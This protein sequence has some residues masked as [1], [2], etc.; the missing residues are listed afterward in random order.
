MAVVSMKRLELCG[1][2]RDRKEILEL[3]QKRAVV[4]VEPSEEGE[5][6]FAK[7]D[8]SGQCQEFLDNA[9]LLE[10]AVELLDHYAPPKKGM[11]SALA[12]RTPVTQR[13]FD[14]L[15]KQAPAL[16]GTAKELLAL[17]KER[18]DGTAQILRLEAQVESLK[19]WL[20][21]D[22]PMNLRETEST[23][24]FLGAFPQELD[25]AALKNS[26]AR[27]LPQVAG[28]EAEVLSSQP[29]QTCVFVV[30]C[31][32]DAPRVEE[33]LR[34]LGFTYP[35]LVTE[36]APQ[37]QAKQL[38]QEIQQA[39]QRN[40]QLEKEIAAR[41]EV[42]QDLLLAADYY[43]A[44]AE[45]YRVLGELWQ[46]PH[47]FWL[48]GYL[49]ASDA[50]GLLSELEGRFSLWA[51]AVEP[52]PDEDPPVK[53]KNGFFTE[54]VE[55]VVE[56]YSLPGKFEVDPC[57]V[58]AFFYY[59][60]FGMML[61]DAAY[62]ILTVIGSGAALKLFPNMEQKMQR[63]LR[64]FLFCGISTTVWGVL[65]G[66]Y[67]GDAI[68]VI[69]RTFFHTEVTI[70]A[71]W[72]EPLSDPM[73]LLIFSFGVGVAHL[74][75]GLGVQF[76]QLAKQRKYADAIYDVIFWYLLVGG[77][78]VVL[79][80]TEIFQNIAEL[81]FT[82]PG[83]VVTVAG[84]LAGIGA[85]GILFTAGRESRNPVKRF[86]KGLYGLYGVSSY[87]SDILSYSR[88]LALGL[89]TSVISTV[90][91][92]L[93]AMLG[94]SVVGAVFFLLIFLI[95]HSM[96]MAINLLGAYVHTNR[97]Q[98]VEFFGKFYEGGGRA[99]QPFAANTKHFQIKEEK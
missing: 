20:T 60:L 2:K 91:N 70:P 88:L 94:G 78:I 33:A 93:G 49:P 21:L 46:S 26:L 57:R 61:S 92:Q 1:L 24:V 42:R 97:L 53:L 25:E 37:Q 10:Q 99:Y 65:F 4:E 82:V 62:G 11:L 30:C 71:L 15:W 31:K 16:L 69:A 83:P 66:S 35:S 3:L 12:G 80:S 38:E 98:F 29:Q 96:N 76:Y 77:L 84:V 58:M 85:V 34:S 6:L 64:M 86:L 9:R 68:P 63:T 90:F 81:P 32:R 17:G 75:T 5:E 47:A 45:K 7:A 28:I 59:V 52:G 43:G 50:P 36:Q 22:I 54:P 74:F 67:F 73:R 40:Q 23:R 87:L 13:Q 8:T 55:G 89:A 39:R 44:R 14:G 72:F 56:G 19:P 48:T 79:L 41:A 95:G 18:T 51:E 27:L